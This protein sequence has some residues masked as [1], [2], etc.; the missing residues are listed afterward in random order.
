[1]RAPQIR[2]LLCS[3]LGVLVCAV[4]VQTGH[5][6]KVQGFEP[7]DPAVSSTGDFSVQT[8][9][10]GQAAPEPTHQA[11]I[12]T[13]SSADADGTASV[14]GTNAV[15]NAALQ[16]FFNGITITGSP[17]VGVGSGM[18]I[19]FTVG[20]GGALQLTLQYDFLSNEPNQ[21]TMRNDFAFYALFN[22]TTALAPRTDFATVLGSAFTTF[23]GGVPFIN[24]TGL[25]TLTISLVGLAPGSN[26]FLGLG[27]ADKT[28]NDGA[29]GLLVDNVQIVVPEPSV[30]ALGVAGA[31]LLVAVRSR[32][33]KT[34]L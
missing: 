4:F 18:L 24:H 34:K 21:L 1:M 27:I 20:A 13:L 29:S 19:P 8:S 12:T 10:Q 31:V 28:S 14:S 5:A 3:T 11:L 23:S 30:M 17:G 7:G 16:T 33:K 26:Y 15:S 9:F 22:G 6:Q 32:M 2:R 25:Q